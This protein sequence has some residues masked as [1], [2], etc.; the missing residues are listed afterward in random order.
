[1][2]TPKKRPEIPT[3]PRVTKPSDAQTNG[4]PKKSPL[5]EWI[6]T[7]V[8]AV[9]FV[10]IFRNL[11]FGFFVVPTGS[12]EDEVMAGE[13]IVASNLHYGPRLPMT[14]GVPLLNIPIKIF[15]FPYYRLPG[16]S[17]IQRGDVVVFNLPAEEAPVDYKTPYLKRLIGMPGDSLR[18]V[19]KKVLINNKAL[20]QKDKMQ[21]MWNIKYNDGN[22][23]VSESMTQAEAQ[24]MVQKGYIDAVT[25][26]ILDQNQT[27][28]DQIFPKGRP[29]NQH[30]YG[31]IWIPKAG[32]TVTLTEE[33]WPLYYR[34]I[35]NYEGHQAQNLGNGQ[36]EID[37]VKTN[38]YTFKMNYYWMMGDNRD[39]SL[40]SRFWGFV[41]ENHIVAKALFVLFSFDLKEKWFRFDH[42]FRM[43]HSG[44]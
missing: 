3:T 23:V 15:N 6:E 14:L 34:I 27:L 41:P 21:Q 12:M 25:P 11:F 9:T 13:Y 8:S 42:F 44:F 24:A 39:D 2:A 20:P 31:P 5:R 29:W 18:I 32:K 10:I 35:T 19:D 26:Y 7:I 30:Q 17:S 43:I 40:D 22:N 1:M 28:P 4:K 37:G 16:F 33:N 36:F 38:R